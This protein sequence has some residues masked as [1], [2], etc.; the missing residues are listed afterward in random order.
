[1]TLSTAPATDELQPAPEEEL[2]QRLDKAE[3]PVNTV[4]IKINQASTTIYNDKG[5]ALTDAGK[6]D[7]PPVYIPLHYP[8]LYIDRLA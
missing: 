3:R 2:Y 1:M 5:E 7:D 6:L 8:K 4:A